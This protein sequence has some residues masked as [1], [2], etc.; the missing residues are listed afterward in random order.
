LHE[1]DKAKDE[2]TQ[3]VDK[4]LHK[5][6]N[7]V[8]G[9]YLLTFLQFFGLIFIILELRYLMTGNVLSPAQQI[10]MQYEHY[11]ATHQARAPAAH[12]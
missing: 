6:K 12:K 4:T 8:S 3:F 7:M 11:Q 5:T 9:N 2:H 1:H 10:K